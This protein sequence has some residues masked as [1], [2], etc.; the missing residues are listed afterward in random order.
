MRGNHGRVGVLLLFGLSV[1][2]DGLVLRKM[3]RGGASGGFGDCGMNEGVL[4]VA[5][6]GT[7]GVVTNFHSCNNNKL[8]NQLSLCGWK[9]S[10][11]VVANDRSVLSTEQF[12]FCPL[13]SGLLLAL[14]GDTPTTVSSCVM[15]EVRQ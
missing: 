3:M 13:R 8:L 11:V 6:G 1:L 4:G 10:R 12:S 5:E 9:A 2:D 7:D 15:M 14:D